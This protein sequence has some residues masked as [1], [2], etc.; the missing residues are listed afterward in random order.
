MTIWTIKG[1]RIYT[2]SYSQIT[3]EFSTYLPI[4]QK[5]IDSF[6]IS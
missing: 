6:E 2:I 3:S 4:I 5:M 1:D